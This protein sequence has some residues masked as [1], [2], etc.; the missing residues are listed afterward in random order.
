MSSLHTAWPEFNLTIPSCIFVPFWVWLRDQNTLVQHNHFKHKI[1]TI[2][3]QHIYRRVKGQRGVP[4]AT[5]QSSFLAP[6]TVL[7]WVFLITISRTRIVFLFYQSLLVLPLR[8]QHVFSNWR[9]LLQILIWGLLGSISCPGHT[10]THTHTHT[11][12]LC[13]KVTAASYGEEL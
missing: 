12:V 1:A 13:D 10:H 7:I 5:A 4:E 2:L 3:W 6:G 8:T 9:C 11:S